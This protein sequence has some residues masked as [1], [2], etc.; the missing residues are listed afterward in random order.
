MYGTAEVVYGTAVALWIV[1]AFAPMTISGVRKCASHETI[2]ALGIGGL[3]FPPLW[4]V[5]M[6][7]AFKGKPAT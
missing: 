4:V 5:A 3:I 7:W 6:V 2:K 1:L